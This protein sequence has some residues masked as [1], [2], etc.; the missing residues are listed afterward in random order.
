MPAT[1]LVNPSQRH[2]LASNQRAYQSPERGRELLESVLLQQ[3]CSHCLLVPLKQCVFYV[4]RPLSLPLG[5]IH[6]P[7]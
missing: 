3:W 4:V 7:F 2:L 1:P 5:M 6:C